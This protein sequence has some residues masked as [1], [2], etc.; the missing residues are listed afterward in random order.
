MSLRTVC[1]TQ[2]KHSL[3]EEEERSGEREGEERLRGKRMRKG[4]K[5]NETNINRNREWEAVVIIE[6]TAVNSKR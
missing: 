2:Q 6:V 5:I 1:E 4:R 3:I